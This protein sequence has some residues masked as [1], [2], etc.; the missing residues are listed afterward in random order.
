LIRSFVMDHFLCGLG[1]F[2]LLIAILKLCA[3]AALCVI[4]A[5]KGTYSVISEEYMTD[6]RHAIIT[7]RN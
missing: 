1:L 3:A 6:N 5:D 2:F 7:N 4:N